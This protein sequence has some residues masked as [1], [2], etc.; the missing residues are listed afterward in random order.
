MN[1]APDFNKYIRRVPQEFMLNYPK[2][3]N[4]ISKCTNYLFSAQFLGMFE[5]KHLGYIFRLRNINEERKTFFFKDYIIKGI[6][7]PI[8]QETLRFKQTFNT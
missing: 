6:R 4:I 1:V 2:M 8:Q 7:E 3:E 5:E